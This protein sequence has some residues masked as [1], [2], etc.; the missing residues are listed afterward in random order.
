MEKAQFSRPG[1]NP[2]GGGIFGIMTIVLLCSAG[3]LCCTG[4]ASGK[5]PVETSDVLVRYMAVSDKPEIP[6]REFVLIHENHSRFDSVYAAGKETASVKRIPA[7]LC[8]FLLSNLDDLGFFDAAEVG[9]YPDPQS[10]QI[11]MVETDLEHPRKLAHLPDE[12][13]GLQH[14]RGGGHL[15]HLEIDGNLLNRTADLGD[16][17]AGAQ[18]AI[19]DQRVM[20]ADLLHLLQQVG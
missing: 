16:G 2:A 17:S 9:R 10:R 15:I 13:A 12:T 14:C 4:C 3:I 7:D 20:G 1:G 19:E 6:S 8:Q 18:P 5:G 11:I